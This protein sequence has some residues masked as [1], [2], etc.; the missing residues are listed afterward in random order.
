MAWRQL[1][2]TD[3][4]GALNANELDSYS[5]A[6]SDAHLP[7]RAE[8]ILANVVQQI[9]EDIASYELNDLSVETDYIPEGYHY[10]ALAIARHRLLSSLPYFEVTE[11]RELEYKEAIKFF[12]SV[13]SGK[14]RPEKPANARDNTAAAPTRLGGAQVATSR[15]KITGRANLSGL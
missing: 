3:L 4:K 15:P 11:A 1:T 14:R 6:Q 9:R 2:I 7:A 13:A 10:H 8:G 12:D 5:S